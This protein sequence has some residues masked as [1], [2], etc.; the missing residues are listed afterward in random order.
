MEEFCISENNVNL[1]EEAL[2]AV[3][4]G[5]AKLGTHTNKQKKIQLHAERQSLKLG[6]IKCTHYPL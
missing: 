5:A 6:E 2:M 4:T 1:M 3:K